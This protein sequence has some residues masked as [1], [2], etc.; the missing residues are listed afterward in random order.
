MNELKKVRKKGRTEK[1]PTGVIHKWGSVRVRRVYLQVRQLHVHYN[2]LLGWDRL[3]HVFLDAPKHQRSAHGCSGRT[4]QIN[5]KHPPRY[6][7]RLTSSH[8][9]VAALP[10]WSLDH[11]TLPETRR[12]SR[13][14]R[15]GKHEKVHREREA[16][17]PSSSSSSASH[18]NLPQQRPQ[19]LNVV[20][21]GR[22][23][24]QQQ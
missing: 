18:I 11:H 17:R 23:R 8:F 15:A 12:S 3:F 14:W 1:T 19:L 22:A 10:R 20:L 16:N 4:P 2:F 6:K 9:A 5:T 24:Q 21:Q 7:A 13:T